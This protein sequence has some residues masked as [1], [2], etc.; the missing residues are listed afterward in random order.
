MSATLLS[1][2]LAQLE[3]A[4]LVERR[5]AARGH[6]YVL[7]E[8]GRELEPI[9]MDIAAWGQ[10]WARDM[11]DDDLDPGFLAWSMHTRLD[12]EAM[13]PGRTAIEFEFSGAPADCRRFWLINE[14]GVVDMCLK[15][16]GHGVDLRVT[17]DL[18]R[19]VEAWRGFRTLRR[20]IENGAIR[21]E[22]PTALRRGFP[23]WLRLS[24]LAPHPRL[25]AGD[26]RRTAAGR[27]QADDEA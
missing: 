11:V 7:T 18:R 6:E 10:R 23:G 16:P 21:L 17:A 3:R 1:Q 26:E 5:P 24:A 12:T 27:A 4:G 19:F 2:R 9:V 15:H 22:G 25:R 20:E 13:P 8:A 14:D